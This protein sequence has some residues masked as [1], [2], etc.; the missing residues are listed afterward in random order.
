[1]AHGR[2]L[3]PVWALARYRGPVRAAIIAGKERGRVD[4]PPILGR[5]VGRAVL[6]AT[7][8]LLT[9]PDLVGPIGAGPVRLTPP[10]AL[11]VRRGPPAE[12][13][14]VGE[15]GPITAWL[16]PAPSRKA[17][18]RSRGGDPVGA[19]AR[20]AAKE[21]AGAGV[22]AGVAPCLVTDRSAVDSVGLSPVQRIGN[23]M[24][25]VRIDPAGL[26]ADRGPVIVIDDVITTGAT[27]IAT[28]DALTGL[29]IPVEAFV[30]VAAAAPWLRAA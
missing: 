5:A 26:P 8:A 19:M 12:S 3:P 11:A 22:A 28:L 30:A 15:R 6:A 21:I 17:A 4:I 1:M 27:L 2:R 16:V 7:G 29:A 23:L 18:A 24:G 20:A 13:L 25:R 14:A 9:F 10:V